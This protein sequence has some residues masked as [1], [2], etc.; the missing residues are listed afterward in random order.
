MKFKYD[1]KERLCFKVDNELYAFLSVLCS[2]HFRNAS[3]RNTYAF[4]FILKEKM[5]VLERGLGTKTIKLNQAEVVALV[6]LIDHI[7]ID[8]F[9]VRGLANPVIVNQ[10]NQIYDKCTLHISLIEKDPSNNLKLII[11]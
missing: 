7:E 4:A 1:N 5:P 2:I 10:V 8:Q 11:S 6:S 9:D 3:N